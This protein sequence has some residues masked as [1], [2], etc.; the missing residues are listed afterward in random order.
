[1]IYDLLAK[2]TDKV[3]GGEDATGS[4][5]VGNHIGTGE[6]FNINYDC[7]KEIE[8]FYMLGETISSASP[9]GCPVL[10]APAAYGTSPAHDVTAFPGTG[11]VTVSP[12]KGGIKVL[13]MRDY[14]RASK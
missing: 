5:Q 11:M 6:F 8:C 9:A 13:Y 10:T 3:S 14:C 7:L 2:E 1:M 4:N 12:T